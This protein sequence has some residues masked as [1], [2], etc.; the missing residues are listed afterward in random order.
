MRTLS[1]FYILLLAGISG[2]EKK[3]FDHRNKHVG[4][5]HLTVDYSYWQQDL[6][7]YD[8]GTYEYDGR[9]WYDK[10]K[11]EKNILHLQ[12]NDQKE[13]LF[14]VSKED[15]ILKY[16]GQ[17]GLGSEI[18]EFKKKHFTLEYS[19]SGCNGAPMGAKDE[20]TISGTEK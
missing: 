2:C 1:L 19:S 11:D 5:Y 18:G 4:N 15:K 20:Y 16:C 14:Q 13:I 8:N 6:G 7:Y 17:A 10:K 12:I 9:I 3:P